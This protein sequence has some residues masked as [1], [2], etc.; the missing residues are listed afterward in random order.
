MQPFIGADG[1]LHN[2][3]GIHAGRVNV[4]DRAGR[5]GY[6]YATYG[7]VRTTDAAIRYITALAAYDPLTTLAVVNNRPSQKKSAQKGTASST[8]QYGGQVSGAGSGWGPYGW[9][10]FDLL[11]FLFGSSGG[12]WGDGGGDATRS[13]T[14]GPPSQ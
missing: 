8:I 2:N 9:S 4:T 11:Q 14:F 6:K 10:G 5:S 1:I 13:L 12:G 3:V 7:C